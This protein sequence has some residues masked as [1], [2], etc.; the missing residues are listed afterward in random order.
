MARTASRP[1]PKRRTLILL[2]TPIVVTTIAGT[3]GNAL[4]PTLLRDHKL[5]LIGLDARNRQLLPVA[6]RVGFVA[7]VVVATLRRFVSDPSFYLLGRLYGDDAVAWLER[8]AGDAGMV[9]RRLER[10]FAHIGP[11]LVFLFPGAVVCVLA[12]ATEMHPVLFAVLNVAGTL[13]MVVAMWAVADQLRGPISS[14]TRFVS[15]NSLWLTVLTVLLTAVY[16]WDQRRRGK[17]R[18]SG[19]AQLADVARAEDADAPSS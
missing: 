5:L 3:V 13:A 7:F 10:L 6:G 12:G 16:L 19:I 9:V 11:V 17:D 2:L 15:D 18:L 8:R 14:F 4:F 1:R